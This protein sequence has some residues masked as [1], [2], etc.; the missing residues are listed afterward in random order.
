MIN[1]LRSK[2]DFKAS[3]SP[4]ESSNPDVKSSGYARA[5]ASQTA[6]KRKPDSFGTAAIYCK[7]SNR[8]ADISIY[9]TNLDPTILSTVRDWITEDGEASNKPTTSTATKSVFRAR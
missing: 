1:F 7:K 4:Y 5:S 3:R 9:Y 2:I 8:T 6:S